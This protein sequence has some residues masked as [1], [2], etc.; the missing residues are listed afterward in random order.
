VAE[1]LVGGAAPRLDLL[2]VQV[3]WISVVV[4]CHCSVSVVWSRPGR[5]WCQGK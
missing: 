1:Q 5:L 4:W 3:V 2:A